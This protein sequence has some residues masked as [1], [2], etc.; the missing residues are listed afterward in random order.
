[1]YAD[2]YMYNG[3]K[4]LSGESTNSYEYGMQLYGS[5]MMLTIAQF[6]K[7]NQN[8][9]DWYPSGSGI[10]KWNSTNVADVLTSGHNVRV[11]VYPEIISLLSFIDR[12][13]LGY[14]F[15]NIE[16]NGK[17]KDYKNLS[18][19]LKHQMTYGIQYNLPFGL[20]RSWHVRYEQPAAFDNRTIVD[21]Q[22]HHQI[23]R[24]ES[25]L[26]ISNVFDVQYEDIEDVTLP[27]RWFK[28]NLRFNL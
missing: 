14:A 22:I 3:N 7:N 13:E 1:M 12:L 20:S 18:H 23:W 26:N 11:E 4:S 25:T 5:A 16:H 17:N 8:V 6:Y 19:Y 21:T 28:F 27:G 15:M 2:D 9:I 24:V 10:T